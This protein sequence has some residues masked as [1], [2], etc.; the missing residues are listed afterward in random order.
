MASTGL[1]WSCTMQ[2]A[3][4]IL[5]ELPRFRILIKVVSCCFHLSSA[6]VRLNISCGTRRTNRNWP[7]VY[8][9]FI[10]WYVTNW[11]WH[12]ELH[13]WM[14]TRGEVEL[15][16]QIAFMI[17]Y[18]TFT[19]FDREELRGKKKSRLQDFWSTLLIKHMNNFLKSHE[20]KIPLRILIYTIHNPCTD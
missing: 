4:L 14:V 5:S 15:S 10:E 7:K 2:L 20:G 9:V 6:W 18:F 16:Q 13:A 11:I 12:A 8:F 1:M 17:R 3:I 19:S